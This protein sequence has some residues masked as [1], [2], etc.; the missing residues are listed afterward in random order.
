MAWSG[1]LGGAA[2]LIAAGMADR[3]LPQVGRDERPRATVAEIAAAYSAK[4][5][6]SGVFVA[7]RRP[8]SVASQELGFL[9]QLKYKID[10]EAETV[11]AWVY[12]RFKKTAVYRP[13]LGVAL[14]HD[15][16]IA[17]LK[18]QARP[19]LI[20]DLSH[21]A[22]EPWP[23][24]DAPSGRRRPAG[25]DEDGLAQAVERMCAEVNRF[26]LRR[27]RAVIVLYD[28][29]IVAERYAEGFGPETRLPGWS[30]TKSVLHALVGIAVRDGRLAVDDKAAGPRWR[31]EGDARAAITIDTM[32]RMS[33]GLAFN[34]YGTLPPS[35]LVRMLFASP[36]AA[37]YAAELPL[38]HRPDTVWAYASGTSNILSRV[39]RRAYGDEAYYAL[40]YRE[41]FSKVGMRRAIIE[42]DASGTLVCSSFMF[43][44][45]RDYARFGLLYAS[46]GV[47]RGE[48]ILPEGWTKYARTATPTAPEG[49]YGAHW[50]LPSDSERAEAQKRGLPLPDDTF[51]ASG[52]EGQK[53]VVIPSRKLVVVRLGLAYFSSFPIYDHVCDVLNALPE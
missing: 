51:N 9:P 32:L 29:E 15:G 24:G 41:L 45:A 48:R 7:G 6:A 19:S 31:T 53:I 11:T 12:P 49:E 52:F 50:W 34:E 14:A 46:D 18:R 33:S 10:R 16:D 30:M 22:A 42:A 20:P 23:T 25:I 17:A 39:L 8:E 2:F 43:A 38:A 27:T 40:P 1:G 4:V 47:W 3:C 44:T 37:G 26:W 36:D 28:G 13:G 35:D 21:L 5:L